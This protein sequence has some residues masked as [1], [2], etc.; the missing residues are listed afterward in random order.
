MKQWILV[1]SVA[2]TWGMLEN[3]F[4]ILDDNNWK[5]KCLAQ[6]GM[7]SFANDQNL[8][9]LW[10]SSVIFLLSCCQQIG[11][12]LLAVQ[13]QS[14]LGHV[15]KNNLEYKYRITHSLLQTASFN[16][17]STILNLRHN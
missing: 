15:L 6:F 5:L 16:I 1:I 14:L 7:P 13:M 10:P 11:C 8:S 9:N 3:Y 2:F 17:T 12:V 4:H